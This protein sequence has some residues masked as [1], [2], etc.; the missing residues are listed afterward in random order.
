MVRQ[1]FF[2][3]LF[4]LVKYPRSLVSVLILVLIQLGIGVWLS[5]LIEA[6]LAT[7]NGIVFLFSLSFWDGLLSIFGFFVLLVLGLFIP[8]M[9]SGMVNSV[10]KRSSLSASSFL[11]VIQLSLWLLVIVLGLMAFFYLMD[12]LLKSFSFLSLFGLFLGTIAA[13]IFF[14]SVIRFVFTPTLIGFGFTLKESLRQSWE[15]TRVIFWKTIFLLLFFLLI[16]SIAWSLVGNV[17][18]SF[19]SDWLFV[20]LTGI[21]QSIL[22]AFESAVLSYTVIHYSSPVPLSQ[23]YQGHQKHSQSSR[24]AGNKNNSSE[25]ASN[26]GLS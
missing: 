23:G 13:I 9:V 16:N 5:P 6:F 3:G 19:D 8:A 2:N 11:R 1:A 12:L 22:V 17:L 4:F 7:G 15:R 14:F 26:R 24:N 21:V 25:S 10:E 18:D 20:F